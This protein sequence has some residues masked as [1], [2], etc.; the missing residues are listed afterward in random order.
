MAVASIDMP[1][2]EAVGHD[3]EV[4]LGWPERH[5]KTLWAPCAN[6]VLGACL[7]ATAPTFDYERD[8]LCWS[9]VFSG[10]LLLV[11]AAFSLSPRHLWA[12]WG[13]AVV[14]L[15]LLFAP[16]VFW[17]PTA[18]AYLNDTLVGS[19]AIVFALVIPGVP[20]L[21]TLP[22][23][24]TPPG[25]T[26]NPSGW[27]Q[28]APIIAL[29]LVGFFISRYL[30]AYQLGHIQTAWD[31]LFIGGTMAVLDSDIS[32]AWPVSDAGLGAIS[33]ILEALTGF[34]GGTRRW[35]SMP[36]LVIVFGILVVPLGVTSIVLIILQP[37]AVGAWCTLCLITAAAMLVM[38]APATDEVIATCQFLAESRRRGEP[39][40]RTFF[41]G[42][43]LGEV[44]SRG[45]LLRNE[46]P[47]TALVRAAGLDNIPWNLALCAALGVWLMFAPD[48]LG[49]VG[50]AADSDHLV[51][52]LVVT[53][54]VIAWGEV[55]R[56]VRY[57]NLL[58]GAWLMVFPWLIESA[59]L[60]SAISDTAIG[61][62]LILFSFR[63]G[64]VNDHYGPWDRWIF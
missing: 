10:V 28:R 64:K 3:E 13:A 59:T 22:G 11:F 55:T 18:A 40:W 17:S 25:W 61:A 37:L 51:G 12:P 27:M 21:R 54:S 44:E 58:L 1:P 38:I 16:L 62:A 57:L 29:A 2:R 36:W 7:I 35:R 52:A 60:T 33:Y 41:F 14:G 34:L 30:A 63:R 53:F 50:A 48:V 6:L 45:E 31:P 56:A 9:D 42:G 46:S 43:T 5:A 49:I 4:A 23:A 19:L 32:K 26:Y 8:A 24:E 15:W 47:V 39:F 20:G